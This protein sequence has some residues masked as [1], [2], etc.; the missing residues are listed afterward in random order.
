ME[1][2]GYTMWY[3]AIPSRIFHNGCST[4]YRQY[5]LGPDATNDLSILFDLQV[6]DMITTVI[7]RQTTHYTS[8]SRGTADFE[9]HV[10]NT[11]DS[12]ATLASQGHM[13]NVNSP[14][15]IPCEHVPLQRFHVGF[16]AR[17]V[18]F[19]AKT[20]HNAGAGLKYIKFE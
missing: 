2:I 3:W 13:L 16:I 18:K 8:Y 20:H 15:N 10:G 17:Y 1:S 14:Q 4:N 7:L 6:T 9:L 12:M 19:T 5:W 11:T